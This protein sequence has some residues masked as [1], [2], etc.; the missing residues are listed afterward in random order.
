MD[1]LASLPNSL[2]SYRLVRN[3]LIGLSRARR[4]FFRYSAGSLF[5]L[6]LT[7]KSSEQAVVDLPNGFRFREATEEDMSVCASDAG[8]TL[9]QFNRRLEAGDICLLITHNDCVAYQM[10]IHW[11]ECF[12]RGAGFLVS[13][14]DNDAYVYGIL[15]NPN[16]RGRG[17]YKKG[18]R[19]LERDMRN[20][21]AHRIIQF[22]EHRNSVVF[23]TLTG[24]GYERVTDVAYVRVFGI[25]IT[26]VA[27]RRCERRK[28]NFFFREKKS[29][30]II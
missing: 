23:H 16:Y 18:L 4:W 11:G 2:K 5:E 30:Y 9:P 19:L 22:A 26:R 25:N 13:A 7:P 10:W 1:S 14:K 29:V 21:H 20:S 27:S 17:L 28:W 6:T 3:V 12:V 15:T 24:A 8:G